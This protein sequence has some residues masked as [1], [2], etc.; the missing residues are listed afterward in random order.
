MLFLTESSN[1]LK[2]SEGRFL[3][4]AVSCLMKIG[5]STEIGDLIYNLTQFIIRMSIV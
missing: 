4:N 2:S 1:R 3:A 5:V